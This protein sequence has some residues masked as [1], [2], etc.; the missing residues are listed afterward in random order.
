[1]LHS[2]AQQAGSGASGLLPGVDYLGI[3]ADNVDP[4]KQQ[5]VRVTIPGL[6]EADVVTDLPWVAPAQCSLFG[7]GDNFG[8]LRV[9]RIGTKVLVRFGDDPPLSGIYTGDVVTGL[10]LLPDE[11]LADYPNKVGFVTPVGDIC[12]TD[13][14]AKTFYYKHNSGTSVEVLA[15]G[16]L[17]I[18]VA[19]DMQTTVAGD[20]TLTVQGERTISV[21]GS[22]VT[23]VQGSNTLSVS[24]S[25]S[26][27]VQGTL[28]NTVGGSINTICSSHT[29][30]GVLNNVDDVV[31]SGHS[32]A[33]HVHKVGSA[34]STPPLN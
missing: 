34:T 30:M 31:A 10:T 3:V 23:T 1:M 11:I 4:E 6:L 19:G 27:N 22:Q 20:Y 14:T 8:V 13:L 32:L 12:Y 16:T 28:S 25:S 24:G 9:P 15:D 29:H 5:R 17:R 18:N 26:V 21:A 7:I 33:T 2:L